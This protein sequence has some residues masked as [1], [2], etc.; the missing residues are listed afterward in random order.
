MTT[1]PP[2]SPKELALLSRLYSDPNW[3]IAQIG[4]KLGRSNASVARLASRLKL[5]R[6]TPVQKPSARMVV[7]LKA[8]ARPCGV[9]AHEITDWSTTA[10]GLA[11]N[12]LVHRGKLFRLQVA[13]RHTVYFTT[14][15]GR[16]AAAALPQFKPVPKPTFAIRTRPG[17]GRDAPMILTPETIYT[18]APPPPVRVLRT[19]T[20]AVW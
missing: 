1:A 6:S 16:D 7:I 9:R 10:V 8:A 5:R 3:S 11:A 13:H 20:H 17:W 18:Y 15:A 2:Y 14:E 4:A 19:S 12:V